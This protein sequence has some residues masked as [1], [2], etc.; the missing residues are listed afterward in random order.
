MTALE[1]L[2]YACDPLDRGGY[3]REDAAAVA[4]LRARPDAR[5]VVIAR[6]MPVLR[7]GAAGLEPFLPLTDAEALGPAR[8]EALLGR[9]PDGAPVF[10]ALLADDAVVEQSDAS[11]GFLDRRVLVVPDRHDLELVDLR[12]LAAGGLVPAPEASV[13]ASAK[14]LLAW[15]ARRS[16]CSNCGA[17]TEVGAGGWRRECP[18][19]KMQHFPRTDPVVIML[20][21]DG[22]ACL[23]GR[24]PRFPKGMYSA[25]AGFLE[26]G[27]TIEQ[28]VRREI[29]EEAGIAGGAVR[30]FASQPWPFPSSL[31]I[32][33]FVQATSRTV[34]VDHV[35]L[36][37]ARWFSRD[38]ALSMLEKRHPN[39]LAAP[40]PMAIAHHLLKA[41]AVSG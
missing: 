37:D 25:L 32:G 39:G 2:G 30:Y 40:I 1:G 4:R 28:A 13:L 7:K 31:M 26:P 34:T 21:T 15:H 6:D 36:E 23:L 29:M 20:A 17:R 12:S 8:V 11:D 10:A 19:C 35:E 9:L 27:E 5:A 22:D 24:Q 33:C 3:L 16:F 41:W 18:A 38:E 14:S